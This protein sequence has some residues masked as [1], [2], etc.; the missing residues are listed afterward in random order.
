MKDIKLEEQLMRHREKWA[1]IREVGTDPELQK[2]HDV[3]RKSI[4]FA[5]LATPLHRLDNFAW[6]IRDG[7]SYKAVSRDTQ[8]S[9]E[10]PR[11]VVRLLSISNHM[12]SI[13]P[14]RNMPANRQCF[15]PCQQH[16][17]PGSPFS[18]GSPVLNWS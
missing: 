9:W 2:Y 16:V 7:E 17:Q 10:H 13:D 18:C 4:P 11:M 12:S 14:Q 5:A 1:R 8:E 15:R 3:T 6:G